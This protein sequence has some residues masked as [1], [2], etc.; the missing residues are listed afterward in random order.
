M[1]EWLGARGCQVVAEDAGAVYVKIDVPCPHLEKSEDGWSCNIYYR[2][3]EGC[4][5]FDG[6]R[7]DFLQCAWKNKALV[8]PTFSHVILEKAKK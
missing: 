6:T 7:Y 2:H 8:K 3:P 1:D 5:V 4:K